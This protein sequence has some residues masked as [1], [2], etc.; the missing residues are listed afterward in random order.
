MPETGG[1]RGGAVLD[2]RRHIGW[3]DDL[4]QTGGIGG[5]ALARA[6]ALLREL[7][8]L[9]SGAG[10]PA[11]ALVATNVLREAGNAA[12]IADAL[13]RGTGRAVRVLS[14]REEA[15]FGFAGA[16]FFEQRPGLLCLVDIGG[17]STEV[18]WGRDATMEDFAG[19]AAGTHRVH[20]ALESLAGGEVAGERAASLLDSFDPSFPA[21]GCGGYRLPELPGRPTM[22]LTGGTAVSLAAARRA[23]RG[24]APALKDVEAMTLDDLAG[25]S[26]WIAGKLR[27]GAGGTLPFDAFRAR[28][29]PAGVMLARSL[30]FALGAREFAV[31]AR[32]A[33]WGVVL[34]AGGS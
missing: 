1:F 21:P 30:L 7:L 13:E 4:V 17:T 32:D 12:E 28:L 2:E 29:L 3:G 20:A 5:G 11:P 34:G 8:D 18:S 23:M 33:R 6:V 15:A 9:S 10:C 26:A 27:A 19:L 14:Q 22:L 24:L 25:V 16:A 31:T